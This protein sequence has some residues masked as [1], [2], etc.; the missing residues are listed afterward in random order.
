MATA[1]AATTGISFAKSH[2]G[3]SNT[4]ATT[5]RR[6]TIEDS[7]GPKSRRS[8][9]LVTDSSYNEGSTH[10]SAV[11]DT[12]ENEVEV[13]LWYS[14]PLLLAIVPAIAGLAF[15]RGSIIITDLALL[16]LAAIYLHWCLLT[17]WY[18]CIAVSFS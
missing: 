3:H 9:S 5:Q 4:N 12:I 1:E 7:R 6:S 8:S 13:S 2:D 11:G 16:I 14:V 15:Q 10:G 17:P 18:V